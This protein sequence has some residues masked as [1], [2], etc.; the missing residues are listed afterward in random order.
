VSG[1]VILAQGGDGTQVD[2]SLSGLPA[3]PHANHLHHGS[4]DAQGEVHVP[5]AELG[6]GDD[7][8]AEGTTSFDDPPL[9]HFGTGHY[10]AVHEAG[11]DTVGAVIGCGDVVA[12][13]A[14]LSAAVSNDNGSI[15]GTVDLTPTDG[16][17]E[18]V[19]ALTG[20]PEGNHANHI[21]HGSCANQGEVHVPLT[22]LDAGSDG[23]ASATTAADGLDFVHFSAGHYYAVHEAGDDTV[24][25]VIACGD[26]TAAR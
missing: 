17:T 6:A 7:G 5:L 16:E 1:T 8:T 25:A 19:V 24:G 20:L 13:D 22:E 9:D 4:C 2:A 10:Y 23:S 12:A 3:G 21:H 15:A 26:V 11:D 18:I 14:P